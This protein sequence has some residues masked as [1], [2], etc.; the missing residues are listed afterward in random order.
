MLETIT[1][2]EE[3]FGAEVTS[4]EGVISEA[5]E[6][7]GQMDKIDP[8]TVT[9]ELHVLIAEERDTSSANA[10]LRSSHVTRQTRPK[11]LI[12][13]PNCRR[14]LMEIGETGQRIMT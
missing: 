10:H 3:I 7:L 11:T 2:A 9:L 12:Q 6:I 13:T 14:R 5:E 1:E 4:E 8:I